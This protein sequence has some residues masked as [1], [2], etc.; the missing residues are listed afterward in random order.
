MV[1]PTAGVPCWDT[2]PTGVP[3][4]YYVSLRSR[5]TNFRALN[6]RNCVN[7]DDLAI[8]NLSSS[9]PWMVVS[10]LPAFVCRTR[11]SSIHPYPFPFWIA[12][13]F[14][15]LPASHFRVQHIN[16]TGSYARRRNYGICRVTQP[17]GQSKSDLFGQN[18]KWTGCFQNRTAGKRW[19]CKKNPAVAAHHAQQQVRKWR[20]WLTRCHR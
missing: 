16:M 18:S 15:Y 19:C 17:W 9:P 14:I 4:N 10:F 1:L 11:R 20:L 3:K 8:L 2:S 6:G 5:Q 7:S 12:I 13:S